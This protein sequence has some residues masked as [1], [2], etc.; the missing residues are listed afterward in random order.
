MAVEIKSLAVG[1][2]AASTELYKAPYTP[3]DP[4]LPKRSAI[5]KA[6]R[7]VNTHGASITVNLKLKKGATEV[8]IVPKDL[9]LGAGHLA[10]L[11]DELTLSPGDSIQGGADITTKVEF[12]VSGVER[13]E[14]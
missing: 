8:W 9:S 10:V 4:A 2:L 11:D 7:L 3:G 5:V 14:V 12:A 13:D 1:T 6:I